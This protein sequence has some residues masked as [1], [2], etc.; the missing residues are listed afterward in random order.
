MPCCLKFCIWSPSIFLEESFLLVPKIRRLISLPFIS[1]NCI[2]V[3]LFLKHFKTVISALQRL[4]SKIIVKSLLLIFLHGAFI[5]LLEN[6]ITI[7]HI[8]NI[9]IQDS[10]LFFVI[11]SRDIAENSNGTS[12]RLHT[13]NTGSFFTILYF[14][15]II[16]STI[17]LSYSILDLFVLLISFGRIKEIF[18][19]NSRA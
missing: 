11:R 13:H 15:Q 2:W 1:V 16:V 9:S 7:D 3:Q 8:S 10:D 19:T 6:V 18:K 4:P 12:A 5:V 14:V 17:R